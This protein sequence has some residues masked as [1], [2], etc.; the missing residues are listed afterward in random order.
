MKQFDVAFCGTS[1]RV[2]ATTP[3][4][5]ALAAVRDLLPEAV[6]SA[7]IGRKT[8]ARVLF[9]HDRKLHTAFSI[10]AEDHP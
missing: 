10:M 8:Y 7:A 5:A 3:L 6:I 1:R 4:E 2:E 9:T